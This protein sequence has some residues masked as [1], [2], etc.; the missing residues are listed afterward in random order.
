MCQPLT[1]STS[2]TPIILRWCCMMLGANHQILAGQEFAQVSGRNKSCLHNMKTILKPQF[3][4]SV[5]Y[6]KGLQKSLLSGHVKYILPLKQTHR[7]SLPRISNNLPL[8]NPTKKLTKN[9]KPAF[10]LVYYTHWW[11]DI[12]ESCSELHPQ[13]EGY[14]GNVDVSCTHPTTNGCHKCHTVYKYLQLFL[15]MTL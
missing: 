6:A 8:R 9:M 10:T 4:Q 13:V 2:T 12:Y 15:L 5:C 14:A 3:C 11:K 7:S 1:F